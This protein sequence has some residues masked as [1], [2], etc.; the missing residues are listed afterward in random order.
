MGEGGTG[1]SIGYADRFWRSAD[2]L[3]LHARDYP[4]TSGPALQQNLVCALETR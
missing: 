1:A 4:A 3:Q 2:G